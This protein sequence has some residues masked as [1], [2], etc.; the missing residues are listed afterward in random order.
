MKNIEQETLSNIVLE[1]HEVIPALEKYNLDF[2]CRGN[3]TLSEACVEKNI[4]VA[5]VAEEMRE[6]KNTATSIKPFTEMTAD[7]L[8][9]H[10]LIYHHFYVKQTIPTIM[11]MLDKITSKHGPKYPHMFEVYERFI[12]VKQDLEPHMQ[13]EE[14]VLFPKIK[15]IAAIPVW[16]ETPGLIA[17]HIVGMIA[18]METEHDIAGQLMYEIRRI[19]SNYTAP[20]DVCTTHKVCLET[21]K[22]FE[23][24][25]HQHVHL[26]NN[27]LFPMLM[28]MMNVQLAKQQ[29][30]V[31]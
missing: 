31:A 10:I 5:T 12:A 15:D 2:C 1:H 7:Q 27:I 25:L 21:L 14:Q 29:L 22:A 9:L 20:E 13:K 4:S 3:K 28:N 11:N 17:S 26:E 23:A 8:I 19:T 6:T 16:K 30:K 18:V 24:D